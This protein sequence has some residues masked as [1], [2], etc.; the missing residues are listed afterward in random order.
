MRRH[1]HKILYILQSWRDWRVDTKS[2]ASKLKNYRQGTGGGGPPP[3][4]E[5]LIAL[6]GIEF[7]TGHTNVI[8]P[9]EVNIAQN[10]TSIKI[11]KHSIVH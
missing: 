8:D 4:E 10:F 1:T 2:K 9:A 6:M 11:F 7:I 3:T 5:R